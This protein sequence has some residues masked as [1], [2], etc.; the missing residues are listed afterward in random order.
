M[1]ING[2]ERYDQH[3]LRRTADA[4]RLYFAVYA[5]CRSIKAASEVAVGKFLNSNGE[6]D[7]RQRVSEAKAASPM[8]T[9]EALPVIGVT[10]V[11]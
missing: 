8:L 3:S 11:S 2:T 7:E 6:R 4:G 5:E 10:P 9:S 1:I